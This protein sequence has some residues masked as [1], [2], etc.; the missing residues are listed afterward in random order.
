MLPCIATPCSFVETR[1]FP[2]LYRVHDSAENFLRFHVIRKSPHSHCGNT[3][4]DRLLQLCLG[5]CLEMHFIEMYQFH[6]EELRNDCFYAAHELHKL[7]KYPP[8]KQGECSS[9]EILEPGLSS[10]HPPVPWGVY[11]TNH[12][13]SKQATLVIYT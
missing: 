3:T 13:F 2:S 6:N 1:I 7:I 12:T 8:S 9:V 11:V 10:L 5:A 4:A